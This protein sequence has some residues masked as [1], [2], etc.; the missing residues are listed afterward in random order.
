MWAEFTR[1]SLSLRVND[2]FESRGTTI[3]ENTDL[4]LLADDIL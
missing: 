3:R 1:V 4:S 2:K